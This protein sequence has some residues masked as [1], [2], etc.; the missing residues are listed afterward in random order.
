MERN[1]ELVDEWRG[2]ADAEVKGSHSLCCCKAIN[3]F[4]CPQTQHSLSCVGLQNNESAYLLIMCVLKSQ[5][6]FMKNPHNLARRKNNYIKF[7]IHS[8]LN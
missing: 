5:Y 4:H 3:I 1:D 8:T 2:T 6:V 7:I